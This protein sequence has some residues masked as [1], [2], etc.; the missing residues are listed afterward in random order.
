MSAKTGKV[1]QE[2]KSAV[3]LQQKAEAAVNPGS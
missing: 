1:R 2:G 3:I